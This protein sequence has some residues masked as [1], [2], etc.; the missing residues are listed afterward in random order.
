[1]VGEGGHPGL[2]PEGT[3]LTSGPFGLRGVAAPVALL[4]HFG[5]LVQPSHEDAAALLV[6]VGAHPALGEEL[7]PVWWQL[8]HPLLLSNRFKVNFTI[9]GIE[10]VKVLLRIGF[11]LGAAIRML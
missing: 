9:V 1:M 10:F 6:V 11:E 2:V 3:T 8:D 4:G 7:G 5:Q